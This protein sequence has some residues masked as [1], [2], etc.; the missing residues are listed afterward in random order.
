MDF[1]Y[2]TVDAS[3]VISERFD[4]EVIAINLNRGTY[5][6]L[7]RTAAEIFELL[8]A[9]PSLEEILAALAIRYGA[10]V[11]EMQMPVAQFMS[12]LESEGLVKRAQAR[13]A[14]ARP[15]SPAMVQKTPFLAPS[16]A[17]HRDMQDLFLLDPIHEVSEAG[18]PERLASAPAD[19]ER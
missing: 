8:A 7:N 9:E 3:G 12:Q 15:S 14:A 19:S 10:P 11:E 16:L 17:V 1:C 5:Y 13:T 2:F 4:D 18:W 6:S